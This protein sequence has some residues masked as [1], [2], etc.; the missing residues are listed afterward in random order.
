MTCERDVTNE[1]HPAR[2]SATIMT[3]FRTQCDIP[4]LPFI[5]HVRP[6]VAAFI[7]A[8]AVLLCC[9]A[10]L[11]RAS[12]KQPVA[13]SSEINAGI[14]I[15]MST[16][17]HPGG[18]SIYIKEYRV[19]AAKHLPR[20]EVEKAVYPFLGPG[21]SPDD[22]E[23]ARAALEKAYRA[24]G[25]QT[26]SV[27][28]PQQ[29][30][31]AVRGGV[32]VLQVV[33]T[34]VGRL[35]IKGA[36]YFLPS[37]IRRGAPS[38]QEGGVVDFNQVTADVIALNQLPDRR[39]TPS[40][41]P[42]VEPN[43]VDIDLDVRDTMPLH[44][45][46]ELNNRYSADTTHLR[47]NGAVNYNNLWQLGHSAGFSF[48]IAPEDVGEVKV[49]SGYY[50]A[51]F[52][53]L[54]CFSLMLEGTKQDSNVSTL[55]GAAVAGRGEF[56]GPHAIWTLPNGKDFYH[57]LNV[58]IDYKHFD[59]NILAG[60]VEMVTPISYYPIS[61]AY[62][63][64]WMN[65]GASTE[66]NGS[67]NFHLR[68]M[69]S[70]ADQFDASRYDAEGNYIYFRGDLSHTHDLPLGLQ[71]YG[72]VQGQLSDQPLINSEQFSAGGLS[73]VR[74][75][76]ESAVLGDNA[77][78]GTLEMRSPS[79]GTWLGKRVDEWR[80]YVFTDAGVLSL[81]Q[82]LPDQES[83]FRL[84]SYGVGSHVR[85]LG[86]CNGSFDLGLPLISQGPV[87]VGDLLLTFR[88]SADF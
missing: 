65:P 19:D 75:Y 20:N 85:F 70:G 68:G 28:V 74:G 67:V 24:S 87:S 22:V 29:S 9:P 11:C 54:P 71:I 83:S 76:I 17:P 6:Y 62:S 45:S 55:G 78:C 31:Q 69:G 58:G 80:F 5:L 81:K 72:K 4:E 47:L 46:L 34:T 84:A 64:S 44:G 7:G 16:T 1:I 32:V 3:K 42:G 35:R 63:A 25:Y 88:I 77:L 82:P 59:Q 30:E 36:R 48:Q 41:R 37:E 15:N 56:F 73:T 51:R 43:T 8:I 39:V 18:G 86:H 52:A 61:A 50:I 49:F 38:L 21:R 12:E 2:Y 10:T 57:S 33:E 40:L 27:Q 53:Q 23:G 13:E 79:L 66:L 26:V 60:G 14:P